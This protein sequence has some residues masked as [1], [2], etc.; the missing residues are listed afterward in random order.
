M[1]LVLFLN[2]DRCLIKMLI[3]Q[4]VAILDLADSKGEESVEKLN[5][6]FGKNRAI[7]IICDVTNRQQF[8]GNF[9]FY[10]H[11]IIQNIE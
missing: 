9:S 2:G 5:K 4:H 7:F 11:Q 1:S 10:H 3:Q 8:K 6:E